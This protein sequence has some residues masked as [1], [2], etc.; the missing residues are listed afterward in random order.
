M[1]IVDF[2]EHMFLK[3]TQNRL[4]Y[5]NL[6]GIENNKDLFLFCVD[7]FCKGLVLCY[8]SNNT[9]NFD[10]LDIDKFMNIRD[11]MILAGIKVDLAINESPFDLPTAINGPELDDEDENKPVHDYH[12]KIYKGYNIYDIQFEVVRH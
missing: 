10:D 4:M 3:N 1:D 5:L 8:G 2:A 11:K 7:L 12:F 6:E 9:V